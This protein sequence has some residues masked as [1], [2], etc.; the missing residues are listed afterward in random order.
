MF[1]LATGFLTKDKAEK[2][3]Q[4]YYK[5]NIPKENIKLITTVDD[6][7]HL[8]RT[9]LSTAKVIGFDA[10][11]KP[12]MCRAGEQDRVS[13]LQL[14]VEDTVYIVD[15]FVLYVTPN[16]EDALKT[17]FTIFFTLSST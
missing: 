3:D 13:I 6:L 7:E 8:S 14:A 4:Q 11:W 1:S 9:L 17:F 16:T 5:L 12:T 2:L 15:L 10:E